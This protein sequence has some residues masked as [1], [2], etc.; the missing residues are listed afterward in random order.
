MPEMD[1]I[2]TVKIIREL[3]TESKWRLPDGTVDPSWF[4]EMPIIALSAN[5]MAGTREEFL[6]AGMNDF[7]PKPIDSVELNT[8][9]RKWLPEDK[10]TTA[11]ESRR[12]NTAP[13]ANAAADAGE[14]AL[15]E[16]LSGIA[17]LD[18]QAG[19][20]HL[21]DNAAAYCD[22]LR[23]FCAEYESHEAA[24]QQFFAAENWKDYA[25][26]VH[27]MKGVFATIG[28]DSLF[29]W[30]RKLELASKAGDYDTC[31]Q[32]TA[33]L[34]LAMRSFKEALEKT[35]L[36]KAVEEAPKI[37]A[38]PETVCEKLRLL[39]DA[40]GRGDSD[41]ADVLAAELA[42]T[43]LNDES[44]DRSLDEICADAR[45]LDYDLAVEK[46]DALLEKLS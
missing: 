44:L 35:S 46:A 17:E 2:E 22:I 24:I 42:R 32:E 23:Q 21:G 6:A 4:K 1:G 15:L 40:C 29:Q 41:E 18:I 3:Q 38:A 25:I 30:A 26:R 13:E 10:F 27:A 43:G 39:R 28:V 8:V 9:L 14:A 19:M 7:I 36:V 37:Q 33:A 12:Q 34:C 31:R 45:N 5:A 11:A 16:E 20:G